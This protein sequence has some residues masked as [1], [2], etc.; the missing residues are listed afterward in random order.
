M[1]QVCYFE[2]QSSQAEREVAFYQA[3]F[4]WAFEK[5]DG[6]PIDYYRITTEGING[7]LLSRP[8]ATPP[9]HCG[10][11]VFTCSIAVADFDATAALIL[12]HGGQV[13]MPKFA[14][15]KRNV[16]KAIFWMPITTPLASYKRMQMR[17]EASTKRPVNLE[18][19]IYRP[20]FGFIERIGFALPIFC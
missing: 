3:V 8:A 2:I 10:T 9:T 6:L 17:L 5:V 19:K 1:N 13:A 11:N 4:G 14:I 15:P 20:L 18:Y 16:G 12:A 7:G